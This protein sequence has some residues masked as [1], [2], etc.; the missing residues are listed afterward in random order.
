MTTEPTDDFTD[1]QAR[2]LLAAAAATIYVDETAPP[3]LTGLP[4]TRPRRWP[5][6][7]AAAAVVVA[8][9]AGYVVSQQLGDGP[10][11]APTVDRREDADRV[12]PV[13]VADPTE[14]TRARKAAADAF[15]SWARGEGP[16]P[17]FADRVRV[18]YAGGG[19]FG[20]TGWVDDPELRSGYAGC[21][22]L[23]FPRCGA[24]PVALLVR[25]QGTVVATA[26]R[27]TCAAGGE[28]PRRFSEAPEDAVRLEEPEP[29]SCE[30]A[31]AVELWI[32][33]EGVIYGVNQAG[34]N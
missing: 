2:R 16:P 15:V 28:V 30:N 4:E 3:T 9:G 25:Y 14:P 19:A 23:G 20:S 13:E 31:W 6:L 11:P 26:G 29:A 7:A 33:D 18:M 24:D 32:D 1:D 21:S 8:I 12:P 17:E 27:S 5:V 34:S 10:Q 22:G